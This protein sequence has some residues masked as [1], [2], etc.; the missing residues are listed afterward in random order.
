[1]S[2]N[3][4]ILIIGGLFESIFAM[5]LG[6]MQQ[7]SDKEIWSWLVIFLASVS[8]SMFLLFKSMGGTHPIPTGTAYAVWAG[9]GA[10]GTVVLGILVFR[11][12]AN[13]WR[14]FFL[15]TLIISIVGLQF[16]STHH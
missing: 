16:T 5:S 10:V 2:F 7:A 15:S 4:I 8:L 6:K 1:M 14:I 12:P 3:W 9:I 11:E 13:F